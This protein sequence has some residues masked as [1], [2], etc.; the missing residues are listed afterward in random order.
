MFT[1]TSK[2]ESRATTGA[3]F[4]VNFIPSVGLAALYTLDGRIRLSTNRDCKWA[5]LYFLELTP[6]FR[7][8]LDGSFEVEGLISAHPYIGN[9]IR[10]L[11]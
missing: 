6:R 2:C 4:C 1:T 11:N 7:E 8:S 10:A 3:I 5:G 9:Q